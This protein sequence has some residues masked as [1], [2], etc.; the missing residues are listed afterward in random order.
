MILGKRTE[1]FQRT[2]GTV[3]CRMLH[4]LIY[5]TVIL[6]VILCGVKFD[7]LQQER[8]DIEGL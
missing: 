1:Y 5:R 4:V 3:Q 7:V 6:T 2:V 8:T